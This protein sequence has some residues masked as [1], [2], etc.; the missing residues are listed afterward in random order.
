M[1][2]KAKVGY[3]CNTAFDHELEHTMVEIYPS[4]RSLV[5]N[6]S[7]ATECGYMKVRIEIMEVLKEEK[8]TY[9]KAKRVRK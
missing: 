2:K 3:V 7:C 6:R 8:L 5:T 4:V 1:K 9:R